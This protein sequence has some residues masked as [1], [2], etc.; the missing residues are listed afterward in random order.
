MGRRRLGITPRVRHGHGMIRHGRQW[1]LRQ[2]GWVRRMD[3]RTGWSVRIVW[4]WLHPRPWRHPRLLLLIRSHPMRW[5]VVHGIVVLAHDVGCIGRCRR[6]LTWKI[7]KRRQTRIRGVTSQGTRAKKVISHNRRF[8][9][10]CH[11]LMVCQLTMSRRGDGR[12]RDFAKRLDSRGSNA[13][14]SRRNSRGYIRSRVFGSCRRQW[15]VFDSVSLAL[16]LSQGFQLSQSLLLLF[17]LLLQLEQFLLGL[18]RL[19]ELFNI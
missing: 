10:A 5:Y 12:D 9:S 7:C 13:W 14:Q 4:R 16:L 18:V 1:L 19:F 11:E 2:H 3:K 15:D 6:F 8:N 17:A